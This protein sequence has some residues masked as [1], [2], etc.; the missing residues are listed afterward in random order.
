MDNHV[1]KF[2]KNILCKKLYFALECIYSF[3]S[4]N[5]VIWQVAYDYFTV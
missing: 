1:R 2:N 5:F 3:L 4:F